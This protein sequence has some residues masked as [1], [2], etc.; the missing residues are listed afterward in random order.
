M[1]RRL[2]ATLFESVLEQ[3][4]N[5]QWQGRFV[6]PSEAQLRAD[7]MPVTNA[8]PMHRFNP[9]SRRCERAY[10]WVTGVL[11]NSWGVASGPTGRWFLNPCRMHTPQC[12]DGTSNSANAG[13]TQRT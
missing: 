10:R 4:Q 5:E 9:A 2:F 3:G 13:R 12:R 8:P 11:R 6:M 7:V 1:V